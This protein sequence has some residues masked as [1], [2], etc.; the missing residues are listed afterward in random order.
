MRTIESSKAE[1]VLDRALKAQKDMFGSAMR[2][3]DSVLAGTT[4]YV[5][6]A[7]RVYKEKSREWEKPIE[8]DFL[9]QK[10]KLVE[11]GDIDTEHIR[12]EIRRFVGGQI[13]DVAPYNV[14]TETGETWD[15]FVMFI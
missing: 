7:G 12:Q 13:G 2:P 1:D 5:T 14:T 9:G 8:V 3:F 6:G 11:V 4:F 15:D 10:R